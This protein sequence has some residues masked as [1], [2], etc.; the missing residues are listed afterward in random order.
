MKICR[1]ALLF[2]VG[3]VT[4]PSLAQMTQITASNL[5]IGSH[6][7]S[8]GTVCAIAVDANENP[9][10]VSVSGG[11]LQGMGQSCGLISAGAITGAVG[12][13]TYVLP[14][15][16]LSGNPGFGYTFTITDTS[17]GQSTSNKHFQLH[18]VPNVTGATWALD[19]YFPTTSVSTVPAFTFATGSGAPS[20]ACAGK[21]FY[22]D[23]SSPSTPVLYSCGQDLTYHIVTGNGSVAYGTTAGTAVQGNDT[24]V[25][26]SLKAQGAYSSGTTYA[27]NDV[28]T[29]AGNDY[30]SLVSGNVGNAPVTTPSKWKPLGGSGGTIDAD[31]YAT[32]SGNNGI[33]N[34]ISSL[35]C[36]N[37]CRI[38]VPATSTD[39]ESTPDAASLPLGTVISDY[40]NGQTV[41]VSN[42]PGLPHTNVC[43]DHAQSMFCDSVVYNR[44][45]T[46]DTQYQRNTTVHRSTFTAFN[47][48]GWNYG[49]APNA[50][51]PLWAY[52]AVTTDT[53][54]VNDRGISQM[55]SSNFTKHATGDFAAVYYGYGYSDCGQPDYSGEGCTG[56]TMETGETSDFFHGFVGAGAT[57]GTTSLPVTYNSAISI[58]NRNATTDGSFILDITKGTISGSITGAPTSVTGFPSNLYSIP[59]STTIPLTTAAGNLGCELAEP[60]PILTPISVTCTITGIVGTNAG[61]FVAGQP[62]ILAGDFPEQVIVSNVGAISGGS[63]SVTFT[64]L[65]PHG[66]SVTSLWQGGLAGNFLSYDQSYAISG[67][68]TILHAYGALDVNH[69]VLEGWRGSGI[70]PSHYVAP[71]TLTN[72]SR[73]SNVVTA[74]GDNSSF[75]QYKQIPSAIISG[76]PD[77]TMNGTISTPNILLNGNFVTATWNQT[78]SDSTCAS[79]TLSMPSSISGFHLYPGVEVR[80]PSIAAP[81]NA[82]VEPNYIAWAN[83][84]V[85]EGPHYPFISTTSLRTVHTVNSPDDQNSA[86][87]GFSQTYV[88][89]GIQGSYRPFFLNMTNPCSWYIGCGGTLAAPPYMYLGSDTS[90]PGA[91]SGAFVL[92]SLPLAGNAII[93]VGCAP[94]EIGGCSNKDLITLWKLTSAG[95]ITV[96]PTTHELGGL[97]YNAGAGNVSGFILQ[98]AGAFCGL[99]TNDA[100]TGV[101][102]TCLSRLNAHVFGIGSSRGAHDGTLELAHLIADTDVLIGG[103]SPC[104][105]DGT[106]CLPRIVTSLTTNGNTGNASLISGVLNI[107]NYTPAHPTLANGRATLVAGTVVV[108]T[109]NAQS[110]SVYSLTNCGVGG[111]QGMLSVGTVVAGTSFT[112]NSSSS[113]DTST[114]CWLIQ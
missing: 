18:K 61:G 54:T 83:G 101:A 111:T 88:G 36:I 63:Q 38:I 73:V 94:T 49:N 104:L 67:F 24:R 53:A 92:N 25:V 3:L 71:V 109:A 52:Q 59:V 13:G 79:A 114:V 108:N 56:I 89:A 42:S 107:P 41:T 106:S 46:P 87:G 31:L 40:R 60:D 21:S 78:G 99:T 90:A 19:H 103:K 84:D 28:V 6:A 50:V 110:T 44:P 48:P 27:L 5:R 45:T 20:T 112:I 34:A 16:A 98:A 96:N 85:L 113:A 93:S 72:L 47:T 58:H 100:T 26:A 9:I 39:T 65:H 55:H 30:V 12:G 4:F 43:G 75:S 81:G 77:S 91:N 102:D 66:Q 95:N 22:Q 57:T 74:T 11:G 7:I 76:C 68:R 37:G 17:V 29:V 97:P 15:E 35:D 14:D 10:T 33:A 32:G 70:P 62:T 82:P 69:V 23:N 2:A 80:G 51:V 86:T 105:A 8:T 64:Y 1:G